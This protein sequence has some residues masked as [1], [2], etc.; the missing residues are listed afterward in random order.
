MYTQA[1]DKKEALR[2]H[3]IAV[4]EYIACGML[5][6]GSIFAPSF[7]E[8][9][10]NLEQRIRYACMHACLRMCMCVYT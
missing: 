10:D 6:P 9:L 4:K 3:A 1:G 8:S 7:K 5:A 2:Q